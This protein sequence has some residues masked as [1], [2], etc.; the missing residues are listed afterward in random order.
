MDVLEKLKETRW[1]KEK[2]TSVSRDKTQKK[3]RDEHGAI[4]RGTSAGLTT[5]LARCD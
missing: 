4:A 3:K 2:K 5:M 1:D